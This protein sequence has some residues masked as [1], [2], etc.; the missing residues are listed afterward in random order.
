MQAASGGAWTC[1]FS[2]LDLRFKVLFRFL[3]AHRDVSCVANAA[4]EKSC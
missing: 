1:N 4:E 3:P 2:F